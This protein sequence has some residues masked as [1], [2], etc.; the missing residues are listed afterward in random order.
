MNPLDSHKSIKRGN[1]VGGNRGVSW[2]D[3]V[4]LQWP[5]AIGPVVT[6][7]QSQ[8]QAPI[9]FPIFKKKKK[10]HLEA[11]LTCVPNGLNDLMVY[12]QH[13]NR[14]GESSRE[15][16]VASVASMVGSKAPIRAKPLSSPIPIFLFHLL[17]MSNLRNMMSKLI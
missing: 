5:V 13:M 1:P 17:I 3:Q 2:V 10:T 7:S 14:L 9:A 8:A 16:G 11:E 15:P 6:K 4:N 12:G